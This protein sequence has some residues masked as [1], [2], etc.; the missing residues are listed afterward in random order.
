MDEESQRRLIDFSIEK[1][2]NGLALMVQ[3]YRYSAGNSINSLIK[4]VKD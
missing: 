2:V 4:N 1:G 3:H